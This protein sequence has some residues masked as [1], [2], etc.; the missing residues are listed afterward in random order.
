VRKISGNG[1]QHHRARTYYRWKKKKP[2]E[3]NSPCSALGCPAKIPHVA[4]PLIRALA[5]RFAVQD[6]WLRWVL[7]GMFE[8]KAS[9]ISDI[10]DGDCSVGI[11]GCRSL[12]ILFPTQERSRC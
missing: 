2:K 12:K 1:V 10:Q 8:L 5:D 11:P 9:L 3:L 4:D 6:K 7:G